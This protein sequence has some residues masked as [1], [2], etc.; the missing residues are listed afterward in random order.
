MS[1]RIVHFFP[2]ILTLLTAAILV[3]LYIR[4][5]RL[6]WGKENVMNIEWLKA[7]KWR[8]LLLIQFPATCIFFPTLEE[9][10]FRAPIIIGFN[11][12]TYYAYLSISISGLLYG[13]GHYFKDRNPITYSKLFGIKSALPAFM[14][15]LPAKSRKKLEEVTDGKKR[16]RRFVITTVL[17]FIFGYFGIKYQSLY[18][19]IGLH[20]ANNVLAIVV[21][22]SAS[23]FL[24][25]GQWL[26]VRQKKQKEETSNKQK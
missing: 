18:L 8:N 20:M 23:L 11:N 7:H 3:F 2:S 12:L 16:W 10:I 6:A 19:S 13:V 14:S 21:V 15:T 24:R 25:A 9:L 26:Q 22:I 17:G 5:I 1:E 4:L